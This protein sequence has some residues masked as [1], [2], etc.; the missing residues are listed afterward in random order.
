MQGLIILVMVKADPVQ[1]GQVHVVGG[2]RELWGWQLST[3]A[4]RPVPA[5]PSVQE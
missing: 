1:Q 2:V 3:G 4:I 5:L